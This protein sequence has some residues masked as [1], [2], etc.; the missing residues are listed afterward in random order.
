MKKSFLAV[1]V[2]AIAFTAIT[3]E[4]IVI[5]EP[6]GTNDPV[7]LFIKVTDSETGKPI[8]RVNC[9]IAPIDRG[10]S[11]GVDGEYEISLYTGRMTFTFSHLGYFSKSYTVFLTGPGTLEIQL[12]T[13][14][15]ELQEII[16]TGNSD[17]NVKGTTIGK[18]EL[19]IE[20]IKALPLFAGQVDVIKSL[21]LLPG[22][23]SVGEVSSGLNVR[24]MMVPRKI[25]Q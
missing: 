9:R 17:Q 21:T 24:G 11:T 15:K 19:S 13:S 14:I 25:G 4:Q 20:S 16:V 12:E 5:G 8:P 23:T 6:T 3:Q 18:N 1:F 10:F 7:S 2:L 22:V